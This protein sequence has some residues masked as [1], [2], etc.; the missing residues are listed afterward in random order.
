M[1]NVW[2]GD[3]DDLLMPEHMR[4][5]PPELKT[6]NLT[7][8]EPF[9]RDG[10]VEFVREVRSR[11]P[12][13]A[14][15]ISTNGLLADRI[16]EQMSE[17]RDIDPGI[18]LAVSLDGVGKAHDRI[19]GTPGAFDRAVELIE[20]LKAAGYR[21]LRLS[22]TLCRDNLDQLAAVARLAGKLD[23][24][25]GIVAAHCA[26][27]HLGLHDGDLAGGPVPNR[28]ADAFGEVVRPW[29]RSWR[30][31]NW[32]RAHFAWRTY[33]YLAA[34]RPTAR[35]GA[36]GDM[37]F[38]QADGT[39]Y[40]CS[41]SGREMGNIIDEDWSEIWTGPRAEAARDF[42]ARCGERCWMICT[43]RSTYRRRPLGVLA[44]VAW[45]KL[46]A[47]LRL[48]RIRDLS[49]ESAGSSDGRAAA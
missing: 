19:R 14:I 18:R 26:E 32:F 43:A 34:K 7:G 5:V 21:G 3:G 33:Q 31:K 27:T 4:K 29:L 17:I 41:V 42:V 49:A 13:A 10:L 12:S 40:S 30:A 47:H 45:N 2:K 9:L 37:F 25:L 1:C 46:L 23:L 22:M 15:A 24:E 38:L 44:W 28:L 11:C 16:V 20:R 35:C 48:L 8:G 39:V 6:I 36:A